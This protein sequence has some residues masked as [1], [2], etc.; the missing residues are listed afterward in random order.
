V[1]PSESLIAGLQNGISMQSDVDEM[2]QV[3]T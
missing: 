2:Q 1:A 3:M